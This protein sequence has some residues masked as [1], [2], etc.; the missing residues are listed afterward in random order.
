[1]WTLDA[2]KP[3]AGTAAP[4]RMFDAAAGGFVEARKLHRASLA[5]GEVQ[6][7]P[8]L[9]VDEGSSLAISGA[10]R[11]AVDASGMMTVTRTEALT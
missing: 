1:M 4:H 2:A 6:A 9:V 11:L 5:P 8:L 7:G 10:Q 3:T